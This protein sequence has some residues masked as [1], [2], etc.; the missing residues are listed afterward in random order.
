MTAILHNT[1]LIC[2]TAMTA[3]LAITLTFDRLITC[4]APACRRWQIS[5]EARRPTRW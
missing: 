2:S 5:G 1:A 4:V 3:F